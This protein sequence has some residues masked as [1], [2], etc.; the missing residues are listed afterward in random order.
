MISL[1]FTTD[2]YVVYVWAKDHFLFF[3]GGISECFQP[4]G[5]IKERST[6]TENK[7]AISIND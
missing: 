3:L 5:I 7:S 6:L 4:Q 2:F 1:R